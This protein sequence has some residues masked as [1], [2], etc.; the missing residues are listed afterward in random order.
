MSVRIFFTILNCSEKSVI[1]NWKMILNVRIFSETFEPP[2]GYS[3]W[4]TDLSRQE[5]RLLT[6]LS[7]PPCPNYWPIPNPT[8]KYWSTLPWT[9]D[10]YSSRPYTV[11]PYPSRPWTF[12]LLPPPPPSIMECWHPPKQ[13]LLIFTPVGL[14]LLTWHWNN[15]Q[16]V[17]HSL[18]I[19]L[20]I[21]FVTKQIV[22][23]R[24]PL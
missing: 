15:L 23:W 22:A 2:S 7:P 18:C 11:G 4:A 9:V 8:M 10:P 14:E 13:V 1:L 3:P 20:H 5:H 24:L 17:S 6:C 12:E 16:H 19:Y 21:C